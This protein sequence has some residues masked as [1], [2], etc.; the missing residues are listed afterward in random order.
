[1]RVL[2]AVPQSMRRNKLTLLIAAL[3][4]FIIGLV[5]WFKT[6]PSVEEQLATLETARAIQDEE[7][8]AVQ[9]N[10]ILNTSTDL[11]FPEAFGDVNESITRTQLWRTANYPEIAA[12]ISS[13]Q[14]VINELE[15]AASINKCIFPLP[16]EKE[17]SLWGVSLPRYE[18]FREWSF[19]LRRAINNDLAEG[20]TVEAFN[21]MNIL[22]GLSEHLKYQSMETDYL[23]HIAFEYSISHIKALFIIDGNATSEDLDYLESNNT[24]L[25]HR[26][27]KS[28]REFSQI[29]N[30]LE[31]RS[32]QDLPSIRRL[33]WWWV[34]KTIKRQQQ[35]RMEELYRRMLADRRA[36]HILIALRHFKNRNGHWPAHLD[37]IIDTIP[38]LARV[39]P[40]E[41]KPFIYKTMGADFVLYS[42]GFNGKDENG[43]LKSPGPDDWPIWPR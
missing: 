43:L 14:D 31:R 25:K 10:R 23:I 19:L 40:Y 17:C 26:F 36:L 21:K 37:P 41:S 7:N 11:K 6:R 33:Y 16:T 18:I 8:A 1:M 5:F 34:E 22:A 15:R 35:S 42:S 20:R 3:T 4:V 29:E 27:S 9:Y 13:K 32:M 30:L 12:W 24:D 2:H 38:E 28:Y 39:D